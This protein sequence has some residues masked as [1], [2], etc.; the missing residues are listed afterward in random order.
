MKYLVLT[1]QDENGKERTY[2]LEGDKRQT[3]DR[4]IVQALQQI[5]NNEIKS[6][7]EEEK[8]KSESDEEFTVERSE[9][10]TEEKAREL[11]GKYLTLVINENVTEHACR[12]QYSSGSRA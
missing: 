5:T 6:V 3:N 11:K 12:V 7:T 2:L 8:Y 10:L 1:Y 9:L 4:M